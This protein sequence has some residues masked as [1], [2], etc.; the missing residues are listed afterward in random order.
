MAPT[1]AA[2]ERSFKER[3]RVHTRTRNC[4]SDGA[5]DKTQAIIFIKHQKRRFFD[6]VLLKPRRGALEKRLLSKLPLDEGAQTEMML[7][8]MQVRVLTR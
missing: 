2:G 1:S 5:A 4:L 8:R 3:S 7:L 6:G